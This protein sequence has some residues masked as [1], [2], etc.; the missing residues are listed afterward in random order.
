MTDPHRPPLGRVLVLIPTYNE[1]ENL[2]S[3]VARTRAAVPAAHV[4]VL[5]DSSPDGTGA[6]A[7]DLASADSNVQVLHRRGKEGLGA[8]YL[9]GFAWA[10]DRGYDAT[11][12]MDAD[13]SHQ[14]EQ[15]PALLA[16]AERADVVIG[17]RWVRGGTVVNWPLSRKILSVGGNVYVKVMLGMRVND[18]TGG[19]R[20][21]RTSALHRMDLHSVESQGYGFQVDMTWRAV[22]AGL[23]VVEVPIE[24]V[25]RVIGESKMSG[26]IVQEAMLN[27]TKWSVTHRVGA[28]R[29][30]ARSARARRQE[31]AWHRL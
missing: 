30:R 5:D 15:L 23:T 10:I 26:H 28:L 7:D 11:V 29:G 4:L 16:A 14:P 18:A 25:E 19:Y 24:F 21:Y 22:R 17:S 13:G 31:A 12:E 8:A 9:A 20:V 27:V 1:R 3:I 2:P 6:V